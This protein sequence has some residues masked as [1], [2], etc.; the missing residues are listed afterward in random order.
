[1]VGLVSVISCELNKNQYRGR[2]RNFKGVGGVWYEKNVCLTP[3]GAIY[4][5]L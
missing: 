5:R 1:M 4:F 2:S 3:L